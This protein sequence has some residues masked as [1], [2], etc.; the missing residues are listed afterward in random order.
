MARWH[1][2]SRCKKRLSETIGIENAARIQ[3]KLTKHTLEIATS[4]Q[5][6]GLAEIHLA[7]SGSSTNECRR[8]QLN[9]K[10]FK[11]HTQGKGNLGV[12]LKKQILKVKKTRI[13]PHRVRRRNTI[14]IGTDL[15]T[16]CEKDLLE[17]SLALENKDLVLGPSTDGGYWLIGFSRKLA[18]DLPSWPFCGI[19][20]GT[21]SVFRTTLNKA[22]E[23]NVSF[24]LLR[25]QNDLDKIEDL[26]PWLRHNQTQN[27]AL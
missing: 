27:L 1:G 26:S 11:V 20:W 8:I 4:I 12:R 23:K 21:K 19:K 14:I 22:K 16:L 13:Y 24:H 15:P 3:N 9:Q 2:A 25:E 17:A 10:F 7:L 5:L 6:K 18:S